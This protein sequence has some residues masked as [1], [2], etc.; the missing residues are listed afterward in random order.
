M[1]SSLN[2]RV[3]LA[4]FI[5][6][7][8]AFAK[9]TIFQKEPHSNYVPYFYP[10][11]NQCSQPWA[12]DMM[13]L[14]DCTSD[15]CG[16]V[17]R[18]HICNE[19]CALACVSM[20]LSA[21]CYKIKIDGKELTPTPKELNSWLVENDGY[22]CLGKNCNNMVLKK[23]EEIASE[24]SIT[25]EGEIRSSTFNWASLVQRISNGLVV[26]AHV[27]NQTHFVLIDGQNT[28]EPGASVYTVLDPFYSSTEYEQSEIA[29]VI[30]YKMKSQCAAGL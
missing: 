12:N 13:G 10:Y 28:T 26:I 27:R 17:G 3:C 18:D 29:D 21:L 24:G 25:F 16:G 9:T 1:A 6:L 14:R 2:Y 4:S 22:E 7:A 23:V 19:G 30:V 15:S 5:L 11:Y 20:A 8:A